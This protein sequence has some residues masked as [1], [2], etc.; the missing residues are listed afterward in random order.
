MGIEDGEEVIVS[1][2]DGELRVST[3][4]QALRRCQEYFRSLLPSGVSLVEELIADR[5]REAAD[6]LED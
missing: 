3:R 1:L 4:D 2:H 6:E 5:R